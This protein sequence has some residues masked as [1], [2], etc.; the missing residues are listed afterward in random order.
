[1]GVAIQKKKKK[2]EEEKKYLDL[3]ETSANYPGFISIST[4]LPH[5]LTQN[6]VHFIPPSLSYSDSEHLF[7]VGNALLI[8]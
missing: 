5:L 1:M 6:T 4:E 8:E 7:Y 3:R 2:E